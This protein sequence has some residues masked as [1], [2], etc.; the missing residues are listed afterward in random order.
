[1]IGPSPI[2]LVSSTRYRILGCLPSRYHTFPL[3]SSTG[4]D[5]TRPNDGLLVRNTSPP[6]VLIGNPFPSTTSTTAHN[7]RSKV[8][9]H[10]FLLDLATSF[11]IVHS[12]GLAQETFMTM[13]VSLCIFEPYVVNNRITRVQQLA[14]MTVPNQSNLHSRPLMPGLYLMTSQADRDSYRLS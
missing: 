1:M 13:E 9:S 2:P 12:N 14:T 7:V 11:S 5:S 10:A 3:R 4:R 8:F 6:P